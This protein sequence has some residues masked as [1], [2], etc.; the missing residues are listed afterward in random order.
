VRMPV[1]STSDSV[2]VHMLH[3][4]QKCLRVPFSRTRTVLQIGQKKADTAQPA[5]TRAASS[6]AM[7]LACQISR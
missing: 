4:Q 7:L 2:T 6:R 5:R 3:W 1:A